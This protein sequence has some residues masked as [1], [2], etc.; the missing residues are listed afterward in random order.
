MSLSENIKLVILVPPTLKEEMDLQNLLC[1][2]EMPSSIPKIGHHLSEKGSDT[3][4]PLLGSSTS[5][6]CSWSSILFCFF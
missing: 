2:K 3:M 5:R 1:G 6:D 4:Y